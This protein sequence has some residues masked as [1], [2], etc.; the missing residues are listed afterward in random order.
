MV[1]VLDACQIGSSWKKT[2]DPASLT[3]EGGLKQIRTE[4]YI[5]L[6]DKSGKEFKWCER[7]CLR[8]GAWNGGI[9]DSP[10]P[11]IGLLFHGFLG[12]YFVSIP[13]THSIPFPKCI[14]RI[15]ILL[16]KRSIKPLFGLNIGEINCWADC[17]GQGNQAQPSQV[18]I[19]IRAL[20]IKHLKAKILR[21]WLSE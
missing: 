8:N 2:S 4:Y 11:S 19:R 20:I 7:N 21:V 17:S 12:E 3:G 1:T 6:C 18:G 9:D 15:I 16:I 5:K 13:T 10:S 14:S